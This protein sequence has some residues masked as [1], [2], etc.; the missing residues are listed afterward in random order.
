MS[1]NL[2]KI[3]KLQLSRIDPRISSF[4]KSILCN[5][6]KSILSGKSASKL[7]NCEKNLSIKNKNL[8]FKTRSRLDQDSILEPPSS[9]KAFYGDIGICHE[10]YENKQ[11]LEKETFFKVNFAKISLWFHFKILVPEDL[12]VKSDDF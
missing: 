1:K 8:Q 5:S 4:W 11:S 3:K 2:L 6:R 10:N 12:P 9:E 7:T